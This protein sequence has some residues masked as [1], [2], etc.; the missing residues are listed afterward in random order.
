MSSAS[1]TAISRGVPRSAHTEP[2]NDTRS[3]RSERSTGKG[4]R[5]RAA[6]E[7]RRIE[8]QRWGQYVGD[9]ESEDFAVA[10][11]PV[12]RRRSCRSSRRRNSGQE[13][14]DDFMN[15]NLFDDLTDHDITVTE[16]SSLDIALA[17]AL[18]LSDSS[19]ASPESSR[20]FTTIDLSYENLVLLE[21]V[22]IVAPLLIVNSMQ[23]LL[24]EGT[25]N[26]PPSEDDSSGVCVVCQSEYL[27]AEKLILLPCC[28]NFHHACGTEWLLNYSKLCPVCKH[29]VTE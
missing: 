2:P 10:P 20:E 27:M 18:S 23:E 13:A 28:H 1:T 5:R 25:E 19:S 7:Q 8:Q 14:L 29:D 21:D 12:N 3:N 4:R 24:F 26:Q 17:L 6:A 16:E 9:D 15:G 11:A 22:K